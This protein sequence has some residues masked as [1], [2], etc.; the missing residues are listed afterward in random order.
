M[1]RPVKVVLDKEVK[2]DRAQHLCP[3]DLASLVIHIHL[4]WIRKPTGGKR[5]RISGKCG[6]KQHLW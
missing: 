4:C 6:K 3:V 2:E 1:V 5:G